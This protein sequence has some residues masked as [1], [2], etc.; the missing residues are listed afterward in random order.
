MITFIKVTFNFSQLLQNQK[1]LLSSF[2]HWLNNLD[3]TRGSRCFAL[4]L[5]WS[6]KDGSWIGML[7]PP[8]FLLITFLRLLWLMAVI[9]CFFSLILAIFS[10]I[11]V[12]FMFQ[13]LWEDPMYNSLFV[14]IFVLNN[15]FYYQKKK[16]LIE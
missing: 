2:N 8:I 10:K 6:L 14:R 5:C 4:E 13:M 7:G 15:N 1:N 16:S 9:F 3:G 12:M 11:W